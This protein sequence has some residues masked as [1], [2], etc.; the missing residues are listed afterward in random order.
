MS[1]YK[2]NGTGNNG[3]FSWVMQR[4]SAIILLI[5]IAYHVIGMITGAYNGMPT[6]IL[7]L[8]LIFGIWHGVNGLKMITDDYVSCRKM[9]AFLFLIYW[10]IGIGVFLQGFKVMSMLTFA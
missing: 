4:V 1:L 9:R 2:Y 5:A 6:F 7:G 8:I 10:I 3:I